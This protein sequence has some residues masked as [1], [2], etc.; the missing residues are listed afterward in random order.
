[1]SKLPPR[2]DNYKL[3]RSRFEHELPWYR[4]T[5]FPSLN[6]PRKIVLVNGAFDLM[7]TSHFRLLFAARQA[8]GINGTVVCALDS[9][10]KVR[11]EKGD[12][13]PIMKWTERAAA[14]A[15]MPIS[16][17]TEIDTLEDMNALVAGLQPDLRV[18]GYEYIGKPTR[19]PNIP[20]LF[21]RE[22]SLHTSEIVRRI[23]S[24][25]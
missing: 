13:R 21:I 12:T 24:N 17:L 2:L 11:R 7:H 4:P 19:Y 9:D 5:D 1:M 3:A 15:Y 6:L 22:S 10:A 23:Q 25:L 20:K 14:L 8:A 16:C 18:Q